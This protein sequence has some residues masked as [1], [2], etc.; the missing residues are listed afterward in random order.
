MRDF[1]DIKESLDGDLVVEWGDFADT[2]EHPSIGLN[3]IMR[4]ILNTEPGDFLY[5][6]E[7][8]FSTDPYLGMINSKTNAFEMG[9]SMKSVLA[10]QMFIYYP[11]LEVTPFP[12]SSSQVAFRIRVKSLM[13]ADSAT[14]VYDSHLNKFNTVKA[15]PYPD[16]D[17]VTVKRQV[18][19]VRINNKIEE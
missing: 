11:E 9:R 15:L 18:P 12:V 6:K 3:Q 2:S 5:F 4:T 16:A 13:D 19:P 14:I 10:E 8:G 7:I 17:G 1:T